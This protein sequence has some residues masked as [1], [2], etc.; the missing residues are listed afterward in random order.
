LNFASEKLHC[1]RQIVTIADALQPRIFKGLR[2]R[3]STSVP[4][5]V[6]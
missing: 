6:P 3:S 2:G 1:E 4:S 5:L